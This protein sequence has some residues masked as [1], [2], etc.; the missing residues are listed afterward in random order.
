MLCCKATHRFQ[1][2][3]GYVFPPC[4]SVCLFRPN[5]RNAFP[6]IATVRV[7]GSNREGI[8]PSLK[9][10]LLQSKIQVRLTD[11]LLCIQSKPQRDNHRRTTSARICVAGHQLR[12][13]PLDEPPAMYQ[14]KCWQLKETWQY[15]FHVR[16]HHFRYDISEITLGKHP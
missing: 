15:Q 10:G 5:A 7:Q 16:S 3:N 1:Q 14:G 13:D 12:K 9:N 11:M 6:D 8:A 2:K 4:F